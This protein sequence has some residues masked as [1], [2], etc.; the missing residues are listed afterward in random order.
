MPRRRVSSVRIA[1]I[2]AVAS[3]SA[4]SSSP[5]TLS[6]SS[7]YPDQ[8]IALQIHGG[9]TEIRY[10]DVVLEELPAAGPEARAF[11]FDSK[12]VVALIGGAN[13]ERTRLHPF[14]QTRLLGAGQARPLR[15]RNLAWE[16]DTAFEQA[17]DVNFPS[18]Q[19]QLDQLN[20][21]VVFSQFGQME[22]LQGEAR[23]P[24]FLGA[25]EKLLDQIQKSGRRLVL[26]SPTPF[27]KASLAQYPDLT[28]HNAVL[29]RYVAGLRALAARRGLTFV[30]LFHPFV[31]VGGLTENGVHLTEKGHERVAQELTGQ[32]GIASHAGPVPA[33]L[34][35]VVRELERLWFDYW[36]PM[37]WAFLG[38]TAPR[39]LSAKIGRHR[40][41]ACFPRK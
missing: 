5:E 33:A 22:S 26:V 29:E 38:G 11:A 14:F 18:I 13:L 41:S 31:G 19:Q 7:P 6:R 3:G 39:P 4:S 34:N 30:D 27:E 15:V 21:T 24:E 8:R 12:D 23:F 17:R 9:A 1:S 2:F 35:T 16:G 25:Y 10:K 20:A 40:R 32:L 36:R 28:P 37:N